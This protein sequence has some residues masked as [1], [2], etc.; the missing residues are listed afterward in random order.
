[1]RILYSSLRQGLQYSTTKE[2]ESEFNF[3]V[4]HMFVAVRYREGAEKGIV[5]EK[6]SGSPLSQRQSGSSG[7][8]C[9]HS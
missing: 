2:A 4:S 6:W 5:K 3:C 8:V 7:S 9:R 1:M